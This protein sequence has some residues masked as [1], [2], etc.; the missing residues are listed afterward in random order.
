MKRV[1]TAISGLMPG[2]DGKRVLENFA[3][4]LIWIQA[5]VSVGLN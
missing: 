2:S 1:E 4:S 3:T 5:A